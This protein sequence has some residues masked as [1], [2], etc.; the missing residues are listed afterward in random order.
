VRKTTTV[1]SLARLILILVG[2]KNNPADLKRISKG[3]VKSEK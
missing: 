1:V 3:W 2:C